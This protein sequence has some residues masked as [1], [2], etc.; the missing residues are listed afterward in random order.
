MTGQPR[1]WIE[2]I[3]DALRDLGGTASLQEIYDQVQRR[4]RMDFNRNTNW[5][6]AIRRT[7]EQNSSD[8]EA[9]SGRIDQ[10]FSVDGIGKGVWGL[11]EALPSTPSAIDLPAVEV[12]AG[13]N[14]KPGRVQTVVYRILRDTELARYLKSIHSHLCQVCQS[15]IQLP[16]GIRYAEAHHIK[17]LGHPHD[18]PD[19]QGNILVLCPTHHAMCDLGVLRLDIGNLRM[20][21]GHR[22][23]QEFIDW[24]NRVVLRH[25]TG[26]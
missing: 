17:P 13:G 9:H 21:G 12:S 7:L 2:E 24:H 19:V 25:G 22:I 15:T 14:E 18:G 6:A 26:V 16:D 20:V 5:D 11:R 1:R 3:S 4:G 23:E 8:S 10:F